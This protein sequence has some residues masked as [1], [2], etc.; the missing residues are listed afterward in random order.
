M[1]KII[2]THKGAAP[3]FPYSQAVLADN[4]LY[5]SGQIGLDAATIQLRDGVEAQTR[6]AMENVG[7]ILEAAGMAF[8]DVVK[9]TVLLADMNDFAK[10]NDVYKTF[11][12]GDFPARVAYQ[13]AALPMGASVEIE[14]IAVKSNSSL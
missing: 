14:G 12:T 11:F 3:Q 9:L 7:H 8:T 1:K 6:Q 4:T 13:A 10:V 5:I 2:S